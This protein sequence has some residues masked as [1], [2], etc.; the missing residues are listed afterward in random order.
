MA[1]CASRTTRN[2]SPIKL[3]MS[4]RK[5]AALGLGSLS[6]GWQW[7][8]APSVQ[9]RAASAGQRWPLAVPTAPDPL[10]GRGNQ[11]HSLE[12]LTQPRHG[13]AGA[14]TTSPWT[15]TWCH[16][17]H[18]QREPCRRVA[19]GEPGQRHRREERG[20]DLASYGAWGTGRA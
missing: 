17:H 20:P 11:P 6:P 2:W 9:S 12:M 4:G 15:G 3:S 1:V 5:P 14:P 16:G 19:S 18:R 8:P 10:P 13:T 7:S